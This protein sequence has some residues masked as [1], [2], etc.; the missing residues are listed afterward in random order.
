MNNF[1]NMASHLFY[2]LLFVICFFVVYS[3]TVQTRVELTSPVHPVTVGGI[4]AL[5]CQ[6]WSIQDSYK[7]NLFRVLINGDTEELTTKG[8]YDSRSS[9]G[10][11]G[12]LSKR[13][14]S[15]GSVVL[16]LT[17]VDALESDQ[18][19][20]FCKVY[21]LIGI[22]FNDIAQDSITVEIFTF[23]KNTFPACESDQST[24]TLRTGN[25][26]VLTCSSE[27]GSPVVELNWS[28]LNADVPFIVHHLQ[29]EEST[30]SEITITINE[31][32]NGALFEC[33]MT[34]T[35][36]P[37]RHRS[38]TIG[39]I[40]VE[41]NSRDTIGFPTV[42]S[43]NMN[44][45]K[46]SDDYQLVL[47]DSVCNTSCPPDDQYIV[48]YWAMATV[49]TTILMLIFITTTII[50]CCKYFTIS[51]EV[52]TAQNSFASCDGTEP[53]YVSLQRRQL[54]ERNSMYMSV[55]D[56]NNPGN[57]VLMP[58]EVFDEFY[59]SLSLKKRESAH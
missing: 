54:P 42:K 12:F 36:F 48:L 34:S 9:L 21:S 18:G 47:K 32:H 4:L 13:T 38:C 59:R 10:Q 29:N 52:M 28:C 8:E 1:N 25:K 56:P 31:L 24:L 43:N 45:V 20:Y 3:E 37:D 26:M 49:G 2:T 39:P 55:E 15:D 30:E 7:V 23:P 17:V 14:Y 51:G 58:R 41:Q 6:V 35:G 53:V 44:S 5:Q 50:Y 16:F 27:K 22:T 40:N 57:K 33:K 19:S 46:E 11:R